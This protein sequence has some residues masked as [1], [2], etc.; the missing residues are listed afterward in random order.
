LIGLDTNVLVRYLAQDDAVQ[1]PIA[2][3]LLER[4]LSVEAPGFIS[5][6]AMVETVWVLQRRYKVGRS[7][8]AA[9]IA[10]LL[11]ADVLV[12]QHQPE[13]HA[14]MVDYRDRNG[15]FGDALIAHL[16]LQAGCPRTLTFDRDA[17]RLP[18]FDAPN[19]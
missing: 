13:V 1:S 12:V 19:E 4:Q 18:G 6:V 3:D 9:C 5:I 2:T 10:R 17:L 15:D 14:A 11:Q 16:G 8:L 7:A